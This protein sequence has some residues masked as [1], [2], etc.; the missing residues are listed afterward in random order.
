MRRLLLLLALLCQSARPGCVPTSFFSFF[1]VEAS[2]SPRST[3]AQICL[4]V[5][6]RHQTCV[7]PDSLTDFLESNARS[8]TNDFQ[9][10][11]TSVN[12]T[13]PS[14]MKDAYNWCLPL[15]G[16]TLDFAGIYFPDLTP[17]MITIC[18]AL[19]RYH[20]EAETIYR[21]FQSEFLNKTCLLFY[22]Q[23][24]AGAF[25]QLS[26]GAGT[27]NLYVDFRSFYLGV[28][29]TVAIKAC[30]VCGYTF[31]VQSLISM[32]LE[33]VDSYQKHTTNLDVQTAVAALDEHWGRLRTGQ[34]TDSLVAA[35]YFQTFFLANKFNFE[36]SSYDVAVQG[37]N[38]MK[39]RIK[40]RLLIS[41]SFRFGFKVFGN[42][43]D[44]W[45]SGFNSGLSFT[46]AGGWRAEAGWTAL[47]LALMRWS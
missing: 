30:D 41:A 1:G 10:R 33:V 3:S 44:V 27:N 37:L 29:P 2:S 36:G 21:G 28:T 26:S 32:V 34:P 13:F 16:R 24:M 38:Q 42:G 15:L 43:T 22:L 7:D 45:S 4:D 14:F 35:S 40:G 17:R 47:L 5:Y 23:V 6:L 9:T 31:V 11:M 39:E 8:I 18:N 46:K 20:S 19:V 12:S 25:C